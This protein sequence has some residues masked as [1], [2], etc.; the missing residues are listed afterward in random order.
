M[1]LK[2]LKLWPKGTRRRHSTSCPRVSFFT[3]QLVEAAP[4]QFMYLSAS[5][6]VQMEGAS[7]FVAKHEDLKQI[8]FAIVLT[9]ATTFTHVLNYYQLT[10]LCLCFFRTRSLSLQGTAF[11]VRTTFILQ[12]HFREMLIL[13]V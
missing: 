6:C 10:N 1:G 3:A 8:M 4:A 12:F 7:V 9:Q 2:G 5:S 11:K 13:Y